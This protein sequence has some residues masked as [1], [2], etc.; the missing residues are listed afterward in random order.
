MQPER[1]VTPEAYLAFDAE[2][3]TRH[4]YWHG[5]V[6]A[7]AGESYPHNAIKDDLVAA[8]RQRSGCDV[9]SSGLRVRAPGYG[10]EHYAY[11]DAVVMGAPA[12]FDEATPPTLLNPSVLVEVTSEST[13]GRDFSDKLEAYFRLESLQEYWIV[14]ADRPYL[15]CYERTGGGLLV[16]MVQG[17]EGTLESAALGVAIPLREIYRR[18]LG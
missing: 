5:E 16:H 15:L 7:M 14:E 12:T 6:V 2:A 4:E 17:A 10:R 3:E 1:A 18:V 9:L 8:L 13:R 11:P